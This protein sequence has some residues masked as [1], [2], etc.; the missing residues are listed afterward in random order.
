[1][2]GVLHRG[3]VVSAAGVVK[4]PAGEVRP[5][6]V[7]QVHAVGKRMVTVEVTGAAVVLGGVILD[8]V[9]DR[10]KVASWHLS[11]WDDVALIDWRE[12]VAS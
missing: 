3:G 12:D 7:V 1:M 9:D 5:G 2:Q 4:I 8:G 10:G 11:R 6:D